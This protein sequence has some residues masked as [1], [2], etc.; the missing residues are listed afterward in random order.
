MNPPRSKRIAHL[1]MLREL[2]A[3]A[4]KL[5][6]VVTHDGI[7]FPA[8]A[9]SAFRDMLTRLED[10]FY[11]TLS[12]KQES[13]VRDIY[14]RVFPSEDGGEI[15]LAKDVPRGKEVETPAMLRRENLP[16]RPPGR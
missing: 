5:E 9:Q 13:F 7:D 16:L 8:S 6:D 10:G 14:V 15:V 4:D 11:D 2:V 3:E 1:R 12:A